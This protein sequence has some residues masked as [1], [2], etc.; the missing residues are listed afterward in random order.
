[1]YM[2]VKNSVKPLDYIESMKILEKRVKDVSLGKKGELLWVLEHNTVYTKGKSANENDLIDKKIKVVNTNRGG[3]YTLHSPG[4]KIA[5]FV[6]DLNKR[7]KDIRKLVNDIENC[8]I[9]ILYE[10]KIM[11]FKDKKNIGIWVGDKKNSMKIAAIGIRVKKWIAYHGFSINVS[12]DLSKYKS[13]V[14]CGIKDKGVTSIKEFGKVGS[15]D[16]E[17][18]IIKKFLNTFH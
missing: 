17:K 15:R 2:E 11:S 13:I 1:M 5:Y 16:I 4:Q 9:D 8:I 12:N 10:Y 6:L 18:I 7:K 3:K 14:P